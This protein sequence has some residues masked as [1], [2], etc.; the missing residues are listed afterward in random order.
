MALTEALTEALG[1]AKAG[2]AD[3]DS[4]TT[5]TLLAWSVWE[6]GWR[7]R[8]PHSDRSGPATLGTSGNFLR[9][10]GFIMLC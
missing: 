1:K 10:L 6:S 5:H 3:R 7:L 9:I 8:S 2:Q 4:D